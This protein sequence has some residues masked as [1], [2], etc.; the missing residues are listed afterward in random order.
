MTK[1]YE[2]SIFQNTPKQQNLKKETVNQNYDKKIFGSTLIPGERVLFKNL[3]ERGGTW[4][5]RSYWENDFYEVVYCH[6]ELF[7][8]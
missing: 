3:L 4:K 7:A 6:H 8:R 1:H 2:R 5:F